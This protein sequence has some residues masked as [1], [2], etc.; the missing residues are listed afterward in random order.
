MCRPGVATTAQEMPFALPSAHRV[1]AASI[2]ALVSLWVRG[3]LKD[4][5]SWSA[6]GVVETANHPLTPRYCPWLFMTVM[7]SKAA[8]AAASP[9]NSR[10]IVFR[11][12]R[13]EEGI[14]GVH[15]YTLEADGTFKHLVSVDTEGNFYKPLVID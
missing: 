15:Y 6:T 5:G 1:L 13:D 14:N 4:S 8:A 11:G 10:L 3:V 2:S 12:S 9:P 7:G